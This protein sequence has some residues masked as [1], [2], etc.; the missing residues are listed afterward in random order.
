MVLIGRSD[1]DIK[2][3]SGD[4]AKIQDRADSSRSGMARCQPLVGLRAAIRVIERY[5]IIFAGARSRKGS[6]AT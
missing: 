1:R 6:S 2:S 3:Y 4:I 5:R